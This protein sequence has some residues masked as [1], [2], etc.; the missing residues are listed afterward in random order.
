MWIH[1]KSK[2]LPTEVLGPFVTLGDGAI[3]AIDETKS[4]VS[5]DEGKTWEELSH[6]P[7]IRVSRERSLLRTRAGILVAAF[8][9]LE[10]QDW[11]WNVE[12][13]DADPGTRLPTY[14]MRSLDEGKSWQDLQKL[15]DEWTGCVRD[16]IET[17]QGRVVFTSMKLLN[18]PGRHVTITYSSEDQGQTW[19]SSNLIDLGG[20]GHHD[21]AIEATLE[22]LRDGRIWMLIRTNLD[23]FWEAFSNDGGR[24]WRTI[25]PTTIDASSAPGLLK[26]L[27][28]GRLVLVWNRL[29]PEGESSYPRVGGDR[30]W[31]EEP[32]INHRGELSIAFSEDEGTTWSDSVVIARQAGKSLAYP[33]V[34]ERRPG[35]LW[36][37]TMQDGVR[38]SLRE[39]DFLEK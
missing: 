32:A 29:Y 6:L 24:Y 2:P 26:R 28:S 21:G 12:T 5:R 17:S 3:L 34:Y 7:D 13:S 18:H 36:I 10:E 30:Q 14:V 19:K 4:L 31:S 20:N 22:E 35:E 11:R 27:E 38:L 1:P 9:N 23:F 37:T 15:H 8:M 39:E 16:M 25:R 33:Y